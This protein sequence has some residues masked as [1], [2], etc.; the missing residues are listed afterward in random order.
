M[1]FSEE[2]ESGRLNSQDISRILRE[3]E[4]SEILG[5][6]SVSSRFLSFFL[7]LDDSEAR[8]ILWKQRD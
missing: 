1:F 6:P 5:K 7:S 2:I 4:E 8:P 3:S